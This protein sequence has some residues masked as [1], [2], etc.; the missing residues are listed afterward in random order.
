[1]KP[2]DSENKGNRWMISAGHNSPCGPSS[3]AFFTANTLRKKE[4]ITPKKLK[5]K[6]QTCSVFFF[7]PPSPDRPLLIAHMHQNMVG[8]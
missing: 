6:S 7:S 3:L 1:M 4:E 8:W 2:P 5:I